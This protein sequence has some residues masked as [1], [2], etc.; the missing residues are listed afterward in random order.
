MWDGG[1]NSC[2]LGMLV[3]G[4]S[5]SGV[6]VIAVASFG[7]G[8]CQRRACPS[9]REDRGVAGLAMCHGNTSPGGSVTGPMPAT[10]SPVRHRFNLGHPR[11][12]RHIGEQPGGPIPLLLVSAHTPAA[13]TSG[14]RGV[15]KRLTT[16]Q[17]NTTRQPYVDDTLE[18]WAADRK[19]V[20]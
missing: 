4:A 2:L 11:S 6:G 5:G 15:E 17:Q 14:C 19:S 8:S 18:V 3:V 20:V 1:V 10:H 12:R 7:S 9:E 13:T 16:S